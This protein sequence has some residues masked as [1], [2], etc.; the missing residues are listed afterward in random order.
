[1]EDKVR[2]ALKK[3]R[4]QKMIIDKLRRRPLYNIDELIS[5]A[6]NSLIL[7][8]DGDRPDVIN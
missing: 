4:K 7:Y 8:P 6:R 5:K 3:Y 1:M 2:A